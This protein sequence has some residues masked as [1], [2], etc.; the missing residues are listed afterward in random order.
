[1]LNQ[2]EKNRGLAPGKDGTMK[3]KP[4]NVMTSLSR[5]SRLCST[6]AHW[7]GARHLSG[8]GRVEIHPYSKGSCQGG[9]FQYA[10]MAALATCQK[11]QSWL[12]AAPGL[13]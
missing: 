6:C 3:S 7:A 9:G 4:A 8:D 10:L 1:M 12:A 11:W 2:W 13:A 5:A